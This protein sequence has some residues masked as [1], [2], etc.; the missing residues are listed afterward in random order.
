MFSDSFSIRKVYK[1]FMSLMYMYIYVL[2]MHIMYYVYIICIIIYYYD[3]YYVF[4][5]KHAFRI[6]DFSGPN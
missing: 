4:S 5:P 3:I 1:Y 2:C 6:L